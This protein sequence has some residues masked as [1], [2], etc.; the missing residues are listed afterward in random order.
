VIAEKIVALGIWCKI[1]NRDK[2]Y[3]TKQSLVIWK[4]MCLSGIEI[5]CSQLWSEREVVEGFERDV[6]PSWDTDKYFSDRSFLE[7]EY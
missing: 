1:C 2:Q 4:K 7:Y 5:F 3:T 6:P